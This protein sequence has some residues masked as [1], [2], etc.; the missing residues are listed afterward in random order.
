LIQPLIDSIQNVLGDAPRP[1]PLHV[2]TFGGNCK[3]YV[4]ECV[5]TGWVSSVGSYV[6]KFEEDMAAYT[7][8]KHAVAV[9]TG[10]AGLHIALLM[11]GVERGDEVLCPSLTFVATA[12]AVHYCGGVPHFVD[13]EATSLGID[14]HAIDAYL[15]DNAER[16]DDG[17]CYNKHTGARIRALVGMHAFG[18]PFDLDAVAT[19]CDTWGVVFVEDAAESLGSLHNGR[20]TGTIGKVGVISF[21]GNKILTTGGGGMI[22]TNDEELAAH[23]KHVTTTAKRPHRWAYF[24]DELGYN[25]RLPNLNAALGCG[26]LEQIE[27]TITT[28]RGLAERYQKAFEAVGG[29]SMLPEPAGTRS[30]YWLNVLVLDEGLA[31]QRDTLLDACCDAGLLVRPIWDPMH[32]LPMYDSCPRM[33][34][35]VTENLAQRVINLPSTAGL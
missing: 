31:D 35:P 15:Q 19:L 6:T 26:Q 32:T 21:N 7:G 25:Y 10:T 29:A 18:H 3:S 24:H 17:G 30:N 20:H 4:Q 11:A 23:A 14:A 27:E 34:L 16:R 13:V 9:G 12:N 22:L 8:A 1:V 28:K 33:P 2:P 5:D